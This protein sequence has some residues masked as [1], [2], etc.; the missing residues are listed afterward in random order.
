MLDDQLQRLR[1]I[2]NSGLDRLKKS[3]VEHRCILE[4]LK[5]GDAE[6]VEVAFRE[7]HKSVLNDFA[8]L[9]EKLQTD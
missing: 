4:A 6:Q 1:M 2:S 5:Q 9:K 7:H 8:L 3:A